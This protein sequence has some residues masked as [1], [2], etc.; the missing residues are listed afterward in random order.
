[1]ALPEP[2]PEL[3][4]QGNIVIREVLVHGDVRRRWPWFVIGL[5][6]GTV[7]TILAFVIAGAIG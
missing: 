4:P 7:T 1:L 5:F 3:A 2:E 6:A